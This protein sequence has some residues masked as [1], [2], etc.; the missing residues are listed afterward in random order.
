MTR[1][2]ALLALGGI[3]IVG[4][5]VPLGWISAAGRSFPGDH[6]PEGAYLRI[7]LAFGKTR[8]R[9]CFAYLETA[10]QHA[11]FTVLDYRK[12]SLGLVRNAFNEPEKSRWIQA[13]QAEGDAE[14]PDDLWVVLATK[15]GWDTQLRRDLS[16]IRT[17]EHGGDRATIETALG[18]RYTFRR[19]DNGIWGLT[20]FTAD[21]VDLKDRSAR[22]FAMTE[23]AAQDYERAKAK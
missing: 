19:A 16:G 17:V 21:L 11:L 14:S 2:Q 20:L 15:N 18:T 7:V 13:W 8:L 22:D 12:R 9:D 4:V 10:S 3:G 1:R 23:R 5:G 6:T